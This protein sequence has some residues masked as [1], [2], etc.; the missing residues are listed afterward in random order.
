MIVS[1]GHRELAAKPVLIDIVKGSTQEGA[2]LVHGRA[3]VTGAVKLIKEPAL[4]QPFLEAV[5]I[6]SAFNPGNKAFGQSLG[7]QH[8][9]L[10]G[11]VGTLILA[12]L[13][14]PASQP[15]TRPPGK[16]ILGR[17]LRPPLVM[18]RAP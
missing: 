7:R 8:T 18:A 13:S 12:K 14:V 5:E 9:A 6:F 2:E 4:F 3:E 15:I 16:L 10:D 1:Q 11:G 17:E